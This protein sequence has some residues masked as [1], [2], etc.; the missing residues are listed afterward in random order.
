MPQGPHR[1]CKN[2]KGKVSKGTTGKVFTPCKEVNDTLPDEAGGAVQLGGK[3]GSVLII[4]KLADGGRR[5]LGDLGSL[6]A[7]R[8]LW[9]LR[10]HVPGGRGRRQ[11]R[12]EEEGCG[13]VHQ[14][15]VRRWVT[16]CEVFV[17]CEGEG[18]CDVFWWG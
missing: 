2:Q 15:V 6:D 18:A 14:I 7:F 10:E 3:V 17:K 16:S 11:E 9:T 1:L 4:A 13:G 5:Q 12:K 8:T